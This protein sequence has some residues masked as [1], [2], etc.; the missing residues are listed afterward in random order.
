MPPIRC[1]RP[2][3]PGTAHGRARVSSSRRNG[4]KV[5][6][7]LGSVPL[8]SLANSTCRS[9]R[10]STS[11]TRPRLGAV[12]EVAVGQDEDR[13][14]VGRGDAHGIHRGAEAVGGRLGRRRSAP[15]DSPLRPNMAWSR[16]A[17]SV[18]VGRPV[19]G[20]PRCT[21]TMTSG[22]SSETARPIDSDFR[23]TPGP[24]VVVTPMAPPKLAPR[25]MPMPA[26]SSSA[27]I[28]VTPCRLSAA[29]ACRM[30]EAGVIGYEP[31]TRG[32]PARW[33]AATRPRA[34]AVLPVMLR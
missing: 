28:V 34:S 20:P 10:L 16:S 31:S 6:S 24:L 12:G 1:S 19:E 22:S 29:S 4:W 26:I 13:G 8:G 25:A 3:V 7:P 30:S 23:A 27:C 5:G 14:A 17:C 18:L 15:G 2:G 32:R 11:G 21:S 9:G 33:A